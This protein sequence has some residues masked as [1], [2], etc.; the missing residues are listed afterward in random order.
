QPI[1]GVLPSQLIKAKTNLSERCHFLG[2]LEHQTLIP[3]LR[4]AHASLIS[5][6]SENLPNT[7]IEAVCNLIPIVATHESNMGELISNGK[8][9]FLYHAT[10]HLELLNCLNKIAQMDTDER[11]IMVSH[12]KEVMSRYTPSLYKD[13]I[14]SFYQEA[15]KSS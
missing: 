15:I 8:N 5:S 12:Q 6:L 14:T 7:G 9:G 2:R 13:R 1:D 11:S 3:I 4:G 10:D